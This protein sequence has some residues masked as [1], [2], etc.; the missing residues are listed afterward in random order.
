MYA[1]PPDFAPGSC[2]HMQV[3]GLLP[4]ALVAQCWGLVWDWAEAHRSCAAIS[5]WGFTDTPV[6]WQSRYPG[7]ALPLGSGARPGMAPPDDGYTAAQRAR[8]VRRK[9]HTRAGE[10][11]HGI[12][13][14]GE[15]GYTILLWPAQSDP[16]PV[17]LLESVE[18]DTH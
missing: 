2:L 11:E 15:N 7:H 5:V 13:R 8:K 6:A 10:T 14:T 16:A 4:P 3:A 12:L 9:G 17:R 18:L 1:P